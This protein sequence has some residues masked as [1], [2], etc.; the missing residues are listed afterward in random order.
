[1]KNIPLD[2]SDCSLKPVCDGVEG[3]RELHF[4]QNGM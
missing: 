3:V 2:C 4:K 1:M